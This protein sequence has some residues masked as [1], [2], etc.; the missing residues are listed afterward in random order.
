MGEPSL[1]ETDILAWTEEQAAALRALASRRDLPNELDL[2]NLV[3]EVEALGRSQLNAVESRIRLILGHLAKAVSDPGSPALRHWRTECAVWQ[4]DLLQA[5][6][7][8]MHQRLDM[9]RIWRRA[10][11]EAELA[12]DEHDATLHPRLRGAL[13]PALAELLDPG[14]DLHHAAEAL[15]ARLGLTG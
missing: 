5:I 15:R 7:P 9:D 1:Y 2:G 3:E 14:F 11:R 10:L 12:L 13:P 8:S 4:D 6:S